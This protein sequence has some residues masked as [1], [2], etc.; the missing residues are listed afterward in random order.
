M[1]D[2][3]DTTDRNAETFKSEDAPEVEVRGTRRQAVA[4]DASESYT[5]PAESGVPLRDDQ[6]N[7]RG[8]SFVGSDSGAR[9]PER[10]Q[11]LEGPNDAS[12]G[13]F[14]GISMGILWTTLILLVIAAAV[15]LFFAL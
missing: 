3:R 10:D 2:R 7:P 12:G 6:T 1:T 14:T 15:I 4:G 9:M 5:P 8:T 11:H 13:G